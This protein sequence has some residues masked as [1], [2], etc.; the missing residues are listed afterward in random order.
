MG[1]GS[2]IEVQTVLK[3]MAEANDGH[4]GLVGGQFGQR[5]L[6]HVEGL[7]GVLVGRVHPLEHGDL[8]AADEGGPV[9]LGEGQFGQLSP[10]GPGHHGV[11]DLAHGHRR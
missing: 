1:S 9:G 7:A 11:K 4:V 6:T 5:H 2:K 8:V 10:A 3:L